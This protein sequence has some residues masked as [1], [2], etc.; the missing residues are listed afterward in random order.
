[1]SKRSLAAVFALFLLLAGILP[2]A[3]PPKDDVLPAPKPVPA[4]PL[5]PVVPGA[6]QCRVDRYAVWQNYDVD[7]FG[8]FRPLVINSPSGAYYLYNGAPYP[9][10]STHQFEVMLKTVNTR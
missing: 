1:M 5:L 4:P 8:R 3:D 6:V 2:A 7:R 9:W 10:L